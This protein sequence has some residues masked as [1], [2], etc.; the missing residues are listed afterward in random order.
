MFR[1]PRLMLL[2]LSGHESAREG[3]WVIAFASR[4]PPSSLSRLSLSWPTQFH[5]I[6]FFLCSPLSWGQ[7]MSKHC[8]VFICWLGSG[9][10]MPPSPSSPFL[11]LLL[12]SAMWGGI[13]LW[14]CQASCPV[15]SCPSSVP[16][17]ALLAWLSDSKTLV[18]H[19]HGISVAHLKRSIAWA[20][21]KKTNS[22]AGRP[23]AVVISVTVSWDLSPKMRGCECTVRVIEQ[24]TWK[25]MES[26]SLEML[27]MWLKK[28]TEQSGLV[29]L[30]WLRTWPWW[31]PELL[32]VLSCPVNNF[33]CNFHGV[34]MWYFHPDFSTCGRKSTPGHFS[35][36][37]LPSFQN[38]TYITGFI[39][40]NL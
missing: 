4:V 7:G 15:V 26:P 30:L 11:R 10:S 35:C 31:S 1:F 28:G 5:H 17:P 33:I 16:S 24:V 21:E 19:Q 40:K 6:C 12:L 13:S 2:T 23:R 39:Q 37:Y 29:E 3:W 27:R 36:L 8:R 18:C 9:L 22:I 20:A 25:G 34:F 32:S 38:S 14:L